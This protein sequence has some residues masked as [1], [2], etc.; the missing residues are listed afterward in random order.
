MAKNVLIKPYITEKT[1]RDTEK[2]NRY[3]FIVDKK[4]N[5]IEIKKA[6]E[7][8]YNV[9]VSSVNTVI[10]PAKAKNRMTRGGAIRGRVSSYKKAYITIPEGE[11]IDIY[12]E[13]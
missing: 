12:G 2:L 1:E 10:M 3:T 8:M 9:P 7:A 11:T 6:I 13:L 5:K 4:A